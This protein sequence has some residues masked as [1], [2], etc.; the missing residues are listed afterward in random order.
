MISHVLKVGEQFRITKSG[1]LFNYIVARGFC[2]LT[3]L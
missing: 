2:F 3:H 1:A